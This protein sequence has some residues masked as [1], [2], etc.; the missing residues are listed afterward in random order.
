MGHQLHALPGG[1]SKA[2]GPRGNVSV[3]QQRNKQ[4]GI[5]QKPC[6]MDDLKKSGGLPEGGGLHP[7]GKRKSGLQSSDYLSRCDFKMPDFLTITLRWGL[8]EIRGQPS[9]GQPP[10]GNLTL[11]EGLGD[12]GMPVLCKE[13]LHKPQYDHS[14]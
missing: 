5:P 1:L 3:N 4:G 11:L 7:E 6:E 13:P 2:L 12:I 8:G 14:L 10:D 9:E